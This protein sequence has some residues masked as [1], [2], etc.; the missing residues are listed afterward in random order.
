MLTTPLFGH[1]DQTEQEERY[2][3]TWIWAS[4]ACYVKIVYGNQDLLHW[5]IAEAEQ[6]VHLGCDGL[7]TLCQTKLATTS[8]Q[9]G[10][11]VISIRTTTLQ[12]D[13]EVS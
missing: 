5:Q 11:A 4:S 8:G 7:S 12:R 9:A 1:I 13:G 3:Y 10:L 6:K 2:R